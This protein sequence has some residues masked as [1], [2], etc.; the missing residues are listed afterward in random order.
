MRRKM[1]FTIFKYLFS[2]QRYSSFQ[3]MQ[4]AKKIQ[5][6]RWENVTDLSSVSGTSFI[7]DIPNYHF[8]FA[9]AISMY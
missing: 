3:K 5:A 1:L 7:I 4:L 2:F 8:F 9:V 6:F